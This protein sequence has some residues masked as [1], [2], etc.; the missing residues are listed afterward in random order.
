MTPHRREFD[1][2]ARGALDGLRVVDLSRLVAGNI[3]TKVLADHGAEV[4]KVEPP[5]GD[6][7]RH[8]R[9]NGVSTAWKTLSRNK[10]SVALKLRDVDAAEMDEIQLDQEEKFGLPPLETDARGV[11][12]AADVPAG[13]SSANKPLGEEE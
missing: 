1:P 11:P 6:T 5:E 3:L 10:K 2:S 13:N 7:L 4:V 12:G 8:W 9:I